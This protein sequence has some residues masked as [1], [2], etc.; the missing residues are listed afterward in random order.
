MEGPSVSWELVMQFGS[1]CLL[2]FF[3]LA[4]RL[5]CCDL[6]RGCPLLVG[7][8][9]MQDMGIYYFTSII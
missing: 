8:L 7:A 3:L 4:K 5:F 9:G 6:N 2:V 1:W